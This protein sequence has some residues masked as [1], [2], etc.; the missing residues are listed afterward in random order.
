MEAHLYM[1]TCQLLYLKMRNKYQINNIKEYEM[2]TNPILQN[3]ISGHFALSPLS[4][5]KVMIKSALN[6]MPALDF[7]YWLSGAFECGNLN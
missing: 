5:R 4:D 3:W 1:A 6:R 2:T 7:C